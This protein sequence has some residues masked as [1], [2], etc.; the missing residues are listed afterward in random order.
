MCVCVCVCVHFSVDF[1][2]VVTHTINCIIIIMTSRLGVI[3]Y[4]IKSI[5]NYS[6][7]DVFSYSCL[8][9]LSNER[10]SM[11]KSEDLRAWF[12]HGS[13]LENT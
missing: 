11:F 6:C 3:C 1:E 2:H 5:N 7:I 9:P 12:E 13:E 10:K 8:H 4:A